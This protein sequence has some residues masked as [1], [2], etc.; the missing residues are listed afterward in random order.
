MGG[1]SQE[2]RSP[3]KG[4]EM[5]K[6]KNAPPKVHVVAALQLIATK[7]GFSH[8]DLARSCDVT[9]QAMLRRFDEWR[10]ISVGAAAQMAEAME[11]ELALVPRGSDYPE[12]SIRVSAVL[13]EKH[14]LGGRR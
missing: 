7:K 5:K 11:Y 2:E 13:A 10:N 9:K 12:G 1:N 14:E 4:D 3:E 6:L 8:S